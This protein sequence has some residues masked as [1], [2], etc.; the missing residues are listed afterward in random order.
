M[1]GC[2]ENTT[3]PQVAKLV[4]L[5]FLEIS[6][7]STTCQ[8]RLMSLILTDRD[9]IFLNYE[10]WGQERAT[11]RRISSTVAYCVINVSSKRHLYCHTH[12]QNGVAAA[13]KVFHIAATTFTIFVS[14][15]FLLLFSRFVCLTFF[16]CCKW[17]LL[18]RFVCPVFLN[19]CRW[20]LLSWFVSLTFFF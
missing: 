19:S 1:T 9:D 12:T 2:H 6:M 10:E 8:G 15:T 17:L 14:L 5:I 11:K 7:N 3:L 4:I 13:A 20:L 16:K 18:S